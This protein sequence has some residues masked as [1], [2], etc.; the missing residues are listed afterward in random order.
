MGKKKKFIEKKKSATFVLVYKEATDDGNEE[1]GAGT[2]RIFTRIDGGFSHVPG[3][4]EE[5]PRSQL[6]GYAYGEQGEEEEEEEE[7]EEDLSMFADAEEEDTE[8]AGDENGSHNFQ[9][10][11]KFQTAVKRPQSEANSSSSRFRDRRGGAALP[12]HVRKE[13]VDLGFPDD[14]YDYL[15]HMRKIGAAGVGASF[16]PTNRLQLDRIR[17]DVKVYDSSRV[18]V[19]LV[20]ETTDQQRLIEA[21]GSS[22][23]PLRRPAF[24]EEQGLDPE[25]AAALANS[26][27]GS[28]FDSCDELEDD[29]VIHANENADGDGS[30]CQEIPQ[31]QDVGIHK[32]DNSNGHRESVEEER[33][34]EEDDEEEDEEDV[35]QIARKDT[36]RQRCIRLLDEQFES[37]ALREYDDDMLPGDFDEEDPEARGHADISQ[38]DDVLSEFLADSNIHGDKYKTPAETTSSRPSKSSGP[39][40]GIRLEAC[41]E[42]SHASLDDVSDTSEDELVIVEEDSEDERSN[43]DCETVVSTL[44]NLDNHPGKIL[45]PSKSNSKKQLTLGRVLEEKESN[46]GVIRLRGRHHLPLD[47]LPEKPGSTLIGEKFKGIGKTGKGDK[48]SGSKKP[49]SR[50]GETPEE[51]KLRKAAVKEQ[52]RDARA[53]K[54]ALKVCYRDE[55]QRAQHGAANTGPSGIHLP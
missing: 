13:L 9:T 51:H 14:G 52:R 27:D 53:A 37:L 47:L 39:A 28:Q 41:Q 20:D 3:F 29:F 48:E 36:T 35:H 23:R 18:A 25:V 6:H 12:D 44:S 11:D 4:S 21:V 32:A 45:A 26:D 40:L 31:R 17:T 34:G 42:S 38:F 8:E 46:G 43:W 49:V 54:K 16:V 22:T 24:V 7:E 5:D 50:V 10:A 55:S 1:D 19:N 15:Q 30:A 2:G 33:E